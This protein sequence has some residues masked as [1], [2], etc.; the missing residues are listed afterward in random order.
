VE[1]VSIG[2]QA[3]RPFALLNRQRRHFS[4][5]LKMQRISFGLLISLLL[6]A[7]LQ[8]QDFL[9]HVTAGVGAGFSFPVGTTGNHTKTGFNFVASGGPRFNPHLSLTL[10]F[11]LH[12]LELKNSFTSPTTGADLSLGSTMRMWSLTLNPSYEFI[13]K[14]RLSSYITGGYGLYNRRLLLAATGAIPD[15]ACDEFWG[16]CVTNAPEMVSGN[17]NPYKGGFNAGGGVAFGATNKFFIEVRY[18]H[19]FTTHAATEIIPLTFGIR[20]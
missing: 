8:A 10:D 13:K 2:L 20:W 7:P 14:E 5:E 6:I 1:T 11:S 17:A 15:V 3:N 18:H 12:Y 9:Q 4:I 19:M 16:I